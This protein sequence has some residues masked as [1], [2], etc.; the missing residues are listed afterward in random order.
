MVCCLSLAAFLP[1]TAEEKQASATAV[2]P[3]QDIALYQRF[4]R[5]KFPDVPLQEMAN[6][7][8]SVSDDLRRNWEAIEEF[9]PYG[10]SVDVGQQLWDAPFKNGKA[11]KDC[12][13]QGSGVQHLFPKW[14][15]EAG[16]VVT[17]ALAINQCREKNG[18]K[19]YSYKKGDIADLM[20]YIA[21]QSRGQIIDVMVPKDDPRALAAYQEGKEFYFTRRGQLNF[22]CASCHF[23]SA[24][25]Q[26]RADILSPA[27]GQTTGW[28]VYRS[29]WGELGTLHRRY[30]GCNKQVRAKPFAAQSRQYRNLE[31]FHTHMS[32]GL[33]LNGPAARK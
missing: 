32:N 29:K 14:D 5:K 3:E 23:D 11:Y 4:F 1:A 33:A 15:K 6:G 16:M 12:F 26:L 9:P 24:A 20:S 10:Y 7:V 13:P 21:Y 28:P 25:K 2:S 18:E 22:S 19:A 31:Y 8:Y 17:L 30:A 27:M